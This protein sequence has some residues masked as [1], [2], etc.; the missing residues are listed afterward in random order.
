MP[1]KL[2]YFFQFKSQSSNKLSKFCQ[3]FPVEFLRHLAPSGA[4]KVAAR[5]ADFGLALQNT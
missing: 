1:L 2:L 5:A 3:F 4:K